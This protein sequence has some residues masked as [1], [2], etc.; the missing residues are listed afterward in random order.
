MIQGS[1]KASGGQQEHVRSGSCFDFRDTSRLVDAAIP[2]NFL[3]LEF[4]GRDD[5]PVTKPS[6]QQQD[7]Q[8]FEILITR[9]DLRDRVRELGKEVLESFVG[10]DCVVI[11]VLDGAMIFAADL[12]REMPR[13]L[14][15]APITVSSYGEGTKSSGTVSLVGDLPLGIA[16]ASVLLVDDILDTGATLR[17]LTRLLKEAGADSVTTCVLLRKPSQ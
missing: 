10:R 3:F 16:G 6:V 8:D 4:L 11:P 5:Y 15:M 1:Q 9:D 7:S 17:F 2:I 12:I 13:S 14:R